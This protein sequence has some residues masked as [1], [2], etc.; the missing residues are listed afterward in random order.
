M[1]TDL[2]LL[3]QIEIFTRKNIKRIDIK[4]IN[5]LNKNLK[6]KVLSDINNIIKKKKFKGLNFSDTP[7]LMG[8][9]NLTP[10]S[11]SDGERYIKKRWA[12]NKQKNYLK[13][14]VVY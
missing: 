8:V 6:K 10:D 3:I 11:F 13:M 12:S 7:I 14:D 2:F 1:E 4:N 5:K 9:L